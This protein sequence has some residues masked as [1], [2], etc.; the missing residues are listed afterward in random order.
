METGKARVPTPFLPYKK[1]GTNTLELV[2]TNRIIG[3][4]IEIHKT[5]KEMQEQGA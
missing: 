1:K 4:T 2:E 3:T 5:S